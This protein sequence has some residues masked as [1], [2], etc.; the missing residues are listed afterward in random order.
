MPESTQEA[1][2]RSGCPIASSLDLIGDKWTLVI[3]R[4]LLNGK[5]RFG[6]LLASPEAITTSVLA[7]RLRRMEVAGLI[8]A[9]LY[10]DR[11]QR[12]QY[13]LTAKGRALH[14]V[15]QDLCIWANQWIPGT[16]IPPEKFMRRR[17]GRRRA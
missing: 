14:P 7:D 13:E 16:W 5:S 1:A 11:P 9:K 12:Y 10:E 15:L 2:H 4:D 6:E 3:V 17:V 8:D